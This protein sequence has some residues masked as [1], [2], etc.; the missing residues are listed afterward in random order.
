MKH[1][2]LKLIAAATLSTLAVAPACARAAE[3]FTGVYNTIQGAADSQIIVTDEATSQDGK[4][5]GFNGDFKGGSTLYLNS[6]NASIEMVGALNLAGKVL[7]AP[8]TNLTNLSFTG[9]SIWLVNTDLTVDGTLNYFSAG[10]ATGG[11]SYLDVQG[12]SVLKADRFV[13]DS[14]FALTNR[15][16]TTVREMAVKGMVR[17]K[18]GTMTITESATVGHLWN[19]ATLDAENATIT[20]QTDP[21]MM[22]ANYDG[23]PL[24]YTDGKA[25]TFGNG[26][27]REQSNAEKK[28]TGVSMKV[29]NLIVHGNALNSDSAT[30]TVNNAITVD[31]N[32]NNESGAS[33]A[34]DTATAT[35]NTVTAKADSSIAMTGSSMSVANSSTLGQITA[36]DSDI[37]LGKGTF[38]IESLAGDGAS[39]NITGKNSTTTIKSSTADLSINGT[40]E[41]NDAVDGLSGFVGT[42]GIVKINSLGDGAAT[43]VRLAEGL[44]NGAMSAELD[45]NGNIDPDTIEFSPNSVQKATL[46]LAVSAPLAM[47][48]ALTNDVRKRLGNIRSAQ[49]T[50]GVW[51]RYDGG[52]LSDDSDF[53]HKFN[54]IQIGIDTVPT[55]DSARFGVAF[56]Y[57]DG[58]TEFGRGTS[59]MQAFSLAAYGTWMADNGLFA[60]VIGRLATVKN[61]MTVERYK[62]KTD[63]TLLSLS[64]ELGWRY[65]INKTFWVEPQAELT[66]T[67]VDG[68]KFEL[69]YADY[70][71]DA[72]DS[73]TARAGFALGV[74]CP[75]KKG[76]AYIRASVVHEFL[77]D[78][79]VTASAGNTKSWVEYDGKDTWFEYGIGA[80]Y[81]ITP[82]TYIWADIE[83]TAGGTV[84][85]DIRGTVGIRYSF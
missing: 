57:T 47:T 55:P 31:E 65:A 27:D 17:N 76:D 39:L 28:T 19:L 36:N 54:T 37:T 79:K 51:V 16:V 45:A 73:L 20:I 42:D 64:G 3:T 38:E 43:K 66:Y 21:D 23:S 2:A 7:R 46:D 68:D 24:V 29:K 70:E 85:E 25:Y 11:G 62:G 78:A 61:D 9:G 52:K 49:E 6:D 84:D 13:S 48:R 63:N 50:H 69:G 4:V 53:E 33:L 58:E 77:G 26:V 34:L 67:Y 22:P 30:L 72:S 41:V 40:G 18:A 35:F 5:K 74:Q 8:G 14:Y 15:N 1:F 81:N 71:T 44:V 60:D 10:G 32:F 75:N 82:N 12:T 56:S 59:D 80:S 83:R